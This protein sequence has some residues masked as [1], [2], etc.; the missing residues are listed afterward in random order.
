MGK[1]NLELEIDALNDIGAKAGDYVSLNM[2]T[3]DVLRAA[4][5]IY[6][7]PLFALVIGIVGG[8][9]GFEILNVASYEI[10]GFITGLLF[11]TVALYGI[12]RNENKLHKDERY[13][14]VITDITNDDGLCQIEDFTC[15]VEGVRKKI[16]LEK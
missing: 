10:L 13:L 4:A 6:V 2:E 12:K 8:V 11:M 15:D 9:K 7:I 1:E 14:T 3:V 16:N 5:I